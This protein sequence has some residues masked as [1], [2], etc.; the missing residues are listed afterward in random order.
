MESVSDVRSNLAENESITNIHMRLTNIYGD[1]AVDK[2]TDSRWAKRLASSEQ[3]QGNVS[4]LPRSGRPSTAVTLV[5]M[6]RADSN[7]RNDRRIIT[8][9]LGTGKENVDKTVHHLEYSKLCAR[10][11]SRSLTEERKEQR[12][13]ICSKLLARYEAEVDDFLSIIVTDDET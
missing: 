13:T 1:M 9:E 11:V 10:W 6:Q 12:K 5:T 2:S 7:I 3:G 8:R 4:D